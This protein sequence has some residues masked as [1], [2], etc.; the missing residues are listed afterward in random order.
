MLLA[1]G[2]GSEVVIENTGVGGGAAS[3]VAATS[4]TNVGTS[5]VGTSVVASSTGAGG[6]PYCGPD[7]APCDD[8]LF[9]TGGE[10]CIDGECSDWVEVEC[11]PPPGGGECL[12]AF[13][14][15]AAQGCVLAAGNDG[16]PCFNVGP[17]ME[18]GVCSAGKC[19]GTPTDCSALDTGCTQGVCDPMADG[20]IAVP[21]PNGAPCDDGNPCTSNTTCNA[22]TCGGG[23]SGTSVFFADDFHDASK[24]WTLGNEWQIGP[25]TASVPVSPFQPDPGVD[26]SPSSDNGVA[27]VVIGG[28]ADVMVHP[29][30]YITSPAFS[31]TGP[32]VTLRYYRWLNSDYTPWM[33]N[34]IEVWNGTAWVNVFITGGPPGVQDNAWTLHE[35]DLSP[36]ANGAMR[37]R[38]GMNVGQ[39]GSF[40][41][42]SW[43]IDDVRVTGALCP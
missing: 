7:E 31:A 9:C 18:S 20:C 6:A 30:E 3:V 32:D 4:T 1:S 24:G 37:I 13:C 42:S 19:V 36:H 17:C 11:P 29:F 28:N 39:T 26:H 21:S 35:I 22:G 16:T 33:T 5:V 43:N 25:A 27:G 10:H 23:T 38:F 41:V 2:C 8:G 14:D 40:N 15:E 34:S 12:V